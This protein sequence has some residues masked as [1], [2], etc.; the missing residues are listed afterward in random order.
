MAVFSEQSLA[1][2]RTCH[3]ELQVLFHE[4]IK[5]WDCTILEGYRD[6]ESQDKAF[7]DGKTKL[8]WPMGKHNVSPSHAIDVSPSPVNF[9]KERNFYFF[10]GYVLGIAQKLKEAG[11]M[12]HAIRYGADWNGNHDVTD[13][14]FVDAVHFEIK[15]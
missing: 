12:K 9:S 2:L 5:N 11:I 13:Q 14:S 1:R 7:A 4:V 3:P 6:K 8:K 15:E 10:G